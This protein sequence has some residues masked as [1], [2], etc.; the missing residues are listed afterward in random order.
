VVW[1]IIIFKQRLS[2]TLNR[3]REAYGIACNLSVEELTS[4]LEAPSYENDTLSVAEILGD[5][6]L[7]LHEVAEA[8]ILKAQGYAISRNAVI[9][10]YPDTYRAHLQAM[11]VE[12]EEATRRG[13]SHHRDMR[14]RD[15]AS[16]LEDPMLPEELRPKVYSLLEK[17]CHSSGKQA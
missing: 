16:Y 2:S 12:L 7:L 11:E 4:Y 14:C 15:L 13:L 5:E 6:L 1:N 17:Y 8:C 9:S 3:L 10:A